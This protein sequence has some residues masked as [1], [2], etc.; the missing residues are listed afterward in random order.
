MHASGRRRADERGG[1]ASWDCRVEPGKDREEPS[2]IN[3]P[4]L[5]T[6]AGCWFIFLPPAHEGTRLEAI[7][8]WSSPGKRRRR[9]G[10]ARGLGPEMVQPSAAPARG[11]APS[12]RE[13]LG[14][15]SAPTTRG[16]LQWL[17]E[18]ETK[19]GESLPGQGV[20]SP[21]SRSPPGSM[22]PG[23]QI[24]AN[25]SAGWRARS[26]ERVPPQRSSPSSF[27]EGQENEGCPGPTK[28]HGR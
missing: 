14:G 22:G 15:P 11:F 12:A 4:T 3:T 21:A 23:T 17:D 8:M 6:G 28:E 18:E 27:Q 1:G 7:L 20:T 9:C 2:G 5:L 24:A 13:A 19:G 10:A 26:R 16:C 25:W